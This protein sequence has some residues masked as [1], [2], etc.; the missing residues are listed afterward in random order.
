MEKAKTPGIWLVTANETLVTEM[1]WTLER[2][3]I[4]ET[5]ACFAT[6]GDARDE[7]T[8]RIRDGGLPVLLAV[9]VRTNTVS[10][11]QLVKW[12]AGTD[13]LSQMLMVAFMSHGTAASV[14]HL[15]GADVVFETCPDAAKLAQLHGIASQLERIPTSGEPRP[16][17]A[18]KP[19]KPVA[20]DKS[21]ARRTKRSQ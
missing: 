13:G 7:L 4:G 1:E 12:V 16:G 14:M 17:V 10:G 9:D 21:T 2:A 11:S 15:L 3:N 6:A 5:M 18:Q 8:A 19:T 20:K